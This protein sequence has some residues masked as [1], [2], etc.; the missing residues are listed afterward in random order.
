MSATVVCETAFS[1]YC[2][3]MRTFLGLL[4]T[5]GFFSLFTT[6]RAEPLAV[7]AQAPA[8]TGVTDT[9]DQ[10]DLGAIY[11]KGYTLVYFYP[12]ADTPGC[13]A[14]GCSLRDAYQDLTDRGLTVVGVSIDDVA[15]QKAFKKKY[16]FP[17]TLI[18][19]KDQTVI[20]AFG[21]PTMQIPAM[22]TLAQRQSFLINKEGKIVW[23]DLKASTKQQAADV[24]K[25]L[26]ELGG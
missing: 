3:R 19:D 1:G 12:K 2:F 16:H 13:T 17:F 8:V 21:V 25:A 10:L 23:R 26:K 4:T 14:E 20:K 18:A 9:G 24:L 5:M 11:Q 22:G 7:G 15:A 6:T